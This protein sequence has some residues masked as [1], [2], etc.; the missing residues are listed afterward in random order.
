MG[1]TFKKARN[2]PTWR[3]VAVNAWTAPTEA[4][5]HGSLDIDA[6]AALSYIEKLRI[7]TGQKITISHLVAKALAMAIAKMPEANGIVARGRLF[8]RDDVDIFLQVALDGGVSLSGATIRQAD[9][10]SVA[11]IAKE[12]SEKVA[13]IR[14]HRDDATEKTMDS[15]RR[16]PS[17]LLRPILRFLEWLQYDHD[18]DLKWLGV[19]KDTFGSAMVTNV[20]MFG[21]QQGFAPLFPLGRTAIVLLVGEVSDKPVAVAGQVVIRPMLGL[22]ATVDHRVIDGYHAGVLASELRKVLLDPQTHME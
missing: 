7:S 4:T 17:R 2:L 1:K 3:R 9:R 18:I 19:E 13:D 10:K 14:A 15:M 11:E 8:L 16:I 12:L 20:G 21:L 6:T 22:H 5:I